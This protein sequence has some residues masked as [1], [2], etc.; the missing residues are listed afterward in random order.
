MSLV[1]TYVQTQEGHWYAD[2]TIWGENREWFICYDDD[3]PIELVIKSSSEKTVDT[4][5]Q[6]LRKNGWVLRVLS[7]GLSGQRVFDESF[8]F[9][10]AKSYFLRQVQK[11][12]TDQMMGDSKRL[13]KKPNGQGAY[14]DCR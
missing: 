11:G 7:R 9:V 6:D 14:Y 8:T 1:G 10:P 12:P 13:D 2:P 3:D 4:I 5:L